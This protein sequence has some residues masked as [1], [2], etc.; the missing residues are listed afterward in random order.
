MTVLLV[1]F[2]LLIILIFLFHYTAAVKEGF[3]DIPLDASTIQ[4][5][6]SFLNFYNPFCANWKKAIQTSVATEIPQ[7]PLTD[8]SQV[9]S[10]SAPTISDDEMNAY[11]YKMAQDSSTPFP[12]ICT[13]FPDQINSSNIMQIMQM[14]PKDAQPYI[15]ALTWMNVNL[16][17]AHGNLGNALQGQR[18]ESFEDMCQDL[19]QCLANNPQLAQQLAQNINQQQQLQQQE[20]EQALVG[21][22]N[23]FIVNPGLQQLLQQNQDLV[24]KSQDIQN[25]AQSGELLNQMN[26]PAEQST[27]GQPQMPPGGDKLKQMQNSDPARYNELKQ[28]Y[29][30]WFNVKSLIEQINSNL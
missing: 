18:V 26:L 4:A 24:Q 23:P 9:S 7:Q 29:G 17:K 6:N 21:A 15:N 14:M 20:E 8:P 11:I 5:Y 25:Q 30:L 22:I 27:W 2:T 19:T 16:E 13:Q 28:N 12:P 3:Q 1:L 10:G